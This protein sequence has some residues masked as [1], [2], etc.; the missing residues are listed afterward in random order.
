MIELS[1]GPG[2]L[3]LQLASPLLA[4]PGIWTPGSGLPLEQLGALVTAPLGWQ[5]DGHAIRWE[6][7]A[8]G[9]VWAPPRRPIERYARQLGRMRESLPPLFTLAPDAPGE[10]ERALRFLEEEQAIGYLLWDATPAIVEG[11]RRGAAVLPLL[12]EVPC[13]EIERGVGLVEAG[14]DG[15]WVGPP[16]AGRHGE[17]LWGPAVLPLVLAAL[18]SEALAGLNVPRL[19]GAGIGSAPT[20]RRLIEGGAAAL[21]LGPAWWV[22]PGLAAEV[23]KT[24]P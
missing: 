1:S 12:A 23:R 15:L 16:R 10:V 9:F 17:R 14:A 22:E 20:A 7:V 3:P 13:T 21:A 2:R 5:W 18:Q 11:A 19:A 24:L 6:V 8:G 4:A